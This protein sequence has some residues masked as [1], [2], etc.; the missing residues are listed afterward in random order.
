MLTSAVCSMAIGVG[1]TSATFSIAQ[2]F[3]APSASGD[4]AVST[5]TTAY[6]PNLDLSYADYLDLRDR[7][8]T[9]DGLVATALSR[10]GFSD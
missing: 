9:F 4:G 3:A 8:R 1:A 6:N 10:F 7:N 5:G 2:G